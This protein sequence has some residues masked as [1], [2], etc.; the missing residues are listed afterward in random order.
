MADI[1]S[2]TTWGTRFRFLIRAVGLTGVLAAATGAALLA[3]VFTSTNEW[4]VENLKAAADGARGTFAQVA[5][6]TLAVG[7][8]AVA[9]ALVVELLGTLALVAGRRTAAGTSATVATIA[10]IA[11]LV[12]VNAYSFLHHARFDFTR[13][14]HLTLPPGVTDELRKLRPDVPTT[15]VVFQQ[16]K[17]F[18]TLSGKPDSYDY[19]AERKVVEKVK[20]LVD[21]FR[22]FGPRF[23]VAVLDVE[24][25]GYEHRLAEL[26][27]D[28]PQ[29]KVAIETAPENSIFFA[30][31][32][33]VQRLAFNE[34][35]QLDKTASKQANGGRGN[36]VLLP[37]GVERFARRVLAVHERR[38]KVA[39][40]LAGEWLSPADSEGQEWTSINGL[41]KALTD[42]GFDVTEIVLKKNW[43]RAPATVR[44]ATSGLHASR[45]RAGT[46]GRANWRSPSARVRAAR[47]KAEI[48]AEVR[49]AV[50]AGRAS[51][52]TSEPG[53]MRT[54]AKRPW[55]GGGPR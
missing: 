13:D 8:I 32:G 53:C 54:S 37:Q 35:M 30:A 9:L 36:L 22:E 29:L 19:A 42:H 46:A 44:L 49:K 28:S 38:P 41:K 55:P 11:L 51:R 17:T 2:R 1:R 10:A 25:E 23:N 45:E 6:W 27:Q 26:T 4:T 47:R 18:G 40:C 14:Q 50:D 21:L 52:S 20:D 33:R 3:T 34:F 5:A 12:L 31:N 39:I 7:V 16:H 43:L 15:I 24:D 48:L